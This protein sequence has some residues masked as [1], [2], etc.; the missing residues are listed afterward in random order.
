MLK[1]I[2]VIVVAFCAL[3]LTY[4]TVWVL[5]K[6][7]KIESPSDNQVLRVKLAALGLGILLFVVAMLCF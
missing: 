5:E 2:V 7:F 4:R 3:F 6:I 1:F